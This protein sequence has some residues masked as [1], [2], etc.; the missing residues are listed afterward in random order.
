MDLITGSF[1]FRETQYLHWITRVLGHSAI[2]PIMGGLAFLTF[3]CFSACST[4]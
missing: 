1:R 2:A 4:L 3:Q